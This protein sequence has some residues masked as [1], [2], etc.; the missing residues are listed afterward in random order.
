MISWYRLWPL[1]LLPL[2]FMCFGFIPNFIINGRFLGG[3]IVREWAVNSLLFPLLPASQ[4]DIIIHWWNAA[5]IASE[6]LLYG[7]IMLNLYAVLAPFIYGV[8]H[9]Y[10]KFTNWYNRGTFTSERRKSKGEV[11]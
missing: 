8:G 3:G 2:P 9:L 11:H 1:F 6:C 4:E 7:L 5:S 10:I